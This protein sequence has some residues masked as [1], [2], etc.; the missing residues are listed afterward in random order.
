MVIGTVIRYDIK[1]FPSIQMSIIVFI[2]NYVR[3]HVTH[4]KITIFVVNIYDIKYRRV[5][6]DFEWMPYLASDQAL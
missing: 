3:N 5:F 6:C 1:I 2:T 4:R